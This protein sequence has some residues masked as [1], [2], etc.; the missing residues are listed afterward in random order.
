[1]ASNDGPAEGADLRRLEFL[2]EIGATL[3][4]LDPKRILGDLT[5]VVV[6]E[7]ADWALA[8]LV[9]EGGRIRRVAMGHA[10][11]SKAELAEE[12]EQEFWIVP[13]APVGLPRVIRTGEAEF[14]PRAT[15]ALLAADVQE[16]ERMEPMLRELGVRSWICIPLSARGRVLGALSLVYAESGRNY[17]PADLALAKTLAQRASLAVD[18]ALLVSDLEFQQVLLRS[19]SEATIDGILVVDPEG[20]IISFNQRFVEMWGIP[21]EVIKTGSDEAAI[22]FVV[23]Q[24]EDPEAFIARIRHLYA[25]PEERSRD[26]LHLRD[27]RTFDR[28][29][30]PLTGPDG[31][32]YGR[33][34]YVRDVTDFARVEEI[35]RENQRRAELLAEAGSLFAASLDDRVIAKGLAE[36][37]AR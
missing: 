13:D 27:G 19:Q 29:S 2:A 31:A 6:P 25:H 4:S 14:Y 36:L 17:T 9:E 10:D 34:W 30:A 28:W 15:A 24:L 26:V 7:L 22:E 32:P 3:V 33:A 18:N 23:D 37:V 11:A 12:I 5:R 16:P 20:K 35:L 8:Y 21:P 1:M